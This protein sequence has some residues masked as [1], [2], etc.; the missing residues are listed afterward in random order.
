MIYWAQL[1]HFYQPPTQ[2]PQVLEKICNESYR[3]LLEVLRQYP[4][5]RATLNINGVLLEMLQNH[6]H[7]DIIFSLQSLG[8]KGNVEFTGSGK[9]HPIL[10]LLPLAE[11]KRQIESNIATG[12]QFLGKAYETKGFFP[13]EMC[14]SSEILPEVIAAGHEWIILSGVACPNPWPLD[15]IYQ[16]ENREKKISVFFRDDILSNKI[17]FQQTS[18]HDFL[19]QLKQMRGNAENIY[20]ITAMDAE[21]FG[22]HIKNWENLFLRAVY[23]Q[24]DP[25]RQTRDKIEK[26]RIEYTKEEPV[27]I[28]PVCGT[29]FLLVFSGELPKVGEVTCPNCHTELTVSFKETAKKD[30]GKTSKSTQGAK[31]P[32][33]SRQEMEMVTISELTRLF[34]LGGV[35]IPKAS[36]WSTTA[37]DILAGNPY[38]LWRDKD[39]ETHRLQWEHLYLCIEIVNKAQE[40]ADNDE[41]KSLSSIARTLLDMAEYSCHFWWASRRPMWDMNLIQLGLIDQ[42]RAIVNAYRAINKSGV[43]DKTK[44]NYYHKIV[45][46]RDIRNKIVD[47]LFIL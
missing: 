13:P 17:S 46:A 4:H 16:V 36:S 20:V 39:N 34:P 19:E 37:D 8:E 24:I 10:P 9:Y 32:D 11:R 35:V 27:T 42:W 41:S 26:T 29:K 23:E 15:K 6:G 21:T 43:D 38:P 28:C 18:A 45:A 5:V 3:P 12:T 31:T 33:L 44:S 22:H 14:Y 40:C 25:A 2:T 47:R 7:R 1:L 30:E